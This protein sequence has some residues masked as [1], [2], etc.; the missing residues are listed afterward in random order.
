MTSN[1]SDC[2]FFVKGRVDSQR[3]RIK[4]TYHA[5]RHDWTARDLS[6]NER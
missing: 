5:D 6:F 3:Y 4:V 1:P 2:T